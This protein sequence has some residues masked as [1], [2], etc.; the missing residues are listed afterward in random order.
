MTQEAGEYIGR[1]RRTLADE[2]DRVLDELDALRAFERRLDRIEPTLSASRGPTGP[3]AVHVSTASPSCHADIE[4]I[5]QQYRET[6]MAV[7]HYDEDYGDSLDESLAEEF[8]AELATALRTQPGVSPMLKSRLVD[9]VRTSIEQREV[10]CDALDAERESLATAEQAVT[11]LSTAIDSHRDPPLAA[12]QPDEL[13]SLWE[14][15]CEL[16]ERCDA[17]AA[18]R[19][20]TLPTQT[21]AVADEQ[22]P[23]VVY[24]YRSLPVNYPALHDIARVGERIDDLQASVERYLTRF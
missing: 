6:V 8:G 13:F 22:V 12:R 10:F 5:R 23:R 1:A 19:Q 7:P 4:R 16:R 15:T 14:T 9:A 20:R 21:V 2:D 24:Y 18:E 17:V 11:E 3:T